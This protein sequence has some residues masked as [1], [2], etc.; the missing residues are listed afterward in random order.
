MATYLLV[1][2]FLLTFEIRRENSES[3]SRSLEIFREPY[4]MRSINYNGLA[5]FLLANVL[6]G[7]VNMTFDTIHMHQAA[8]MVV[9]FLYCFVLNAVVC[10][11]YAW[12]IKI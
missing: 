8:S 4:L 12:Q 5:F 10:V 3:S 1:D 7:L 9:M 2:I 11:M 6:T